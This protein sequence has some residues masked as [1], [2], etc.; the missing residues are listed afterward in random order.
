MRVLG[1]ETLAICLHLTK[2]DSIWGLANFKHSR[3][4][5][6]RWDPDNYCVFSSRFHNL[7]FCHIHSLVVCPKLLSFLV[8]D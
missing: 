3:A 1:L 5:P 7:S 8:S 4:F 6:F 2:L